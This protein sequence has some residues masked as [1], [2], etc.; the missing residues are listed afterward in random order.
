MVESGSATRA[1]MFT[2]FEG[3][4][5]SIKLSGA[6]ACKNDRWRIA[7]SLEDATWSIGIKDFTT[8]D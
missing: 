6:I 2:P 4:W 8:Y 5:L 1:T 3:M 7:D